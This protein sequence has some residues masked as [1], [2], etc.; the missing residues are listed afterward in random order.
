MRWLR[1]ECMPGATCSGG[2]RSRYLDVKISYR[3]RG[4]AYAAGV[5]GAASASAVPS[6]ARTISHVTHSAA[7]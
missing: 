4:P 2:I 5:S 7:R 1:L 6:T 3:I